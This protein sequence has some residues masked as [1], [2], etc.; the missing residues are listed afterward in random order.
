MTLPLAVRDLSVRTGRGRVLLDLPK[1]DVDPGTRL[2]VRG[3]SGAGKSTL[4][5]ALAGLLD[6]AQ[7]QVTWGDTQIL[8]LGTSARAAFRA[9]CVGLIFQDF[10]LFDELSPAANAQLAA[11]FAPRAE[12]PGIAAR[13][14]AQLAALGVPGDVRTTASFSG[15]ERQRVAV[16]RALATDPAVLLADEPTGNLDEANGAAVMDLLFGLRDRT[17]ATLIMVTHAPE[18]AARCDRVVRLRDG[19]LAA[20]QQATEAAE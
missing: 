9:R 4:L 11:A 18:L 14:K 3:S 5:F 2:G 19:Q 6:T 7:G 12:R 17:G 10:L 1:L 8:G 13:A 16:S 15:G 20:P